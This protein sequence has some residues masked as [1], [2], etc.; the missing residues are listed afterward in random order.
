MFKFPALPF[1]LKLM[2]DADA[3]FYIAIPSQAITNNK[4]HE[5]LTIFKPVKNEVIIKREQMD[6]QNWE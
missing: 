2:D 5:M 1:T 3:D 4:T 6:R